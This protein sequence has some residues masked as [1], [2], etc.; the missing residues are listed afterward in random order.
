MFVYMRSRRDEGI[1][2]RS[3]E[4]KAVVEVPN[5]EN[6]LLYARPGQGTVNSVLLTF[7]WSGYGKNR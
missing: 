6:A 7:L 2:G 4:G 1:L 3:W 5:G